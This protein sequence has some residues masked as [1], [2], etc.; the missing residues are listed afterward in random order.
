M[1]HDLT[2]SFLCLVAVAGSVHAEPTRDYVI[3]S[4]DTC[5]AIATRELGD[6]KRLEDIHRLNPNLGKAPHNLRPGQTLRLPVA[7][8]SAAALLARTKG[9]VDVNAP[10]SSDWA[11]GVQGQ[12]LYKSWRVATRSE[13]T[14]KIQFTDASSI[15]MRQDTVVVVF[16]SAGS[17]ST[18]ARTQL[19][20]G[21][22]RSR[23]AALDGKPRVSIETPAGTTELVEGSAVLDVD[24][25]NQTKLANHGGRAAKLSGK[26][27]APVT[28]KAGWGSRVD[29][30]KAPETPTP[31]PPAP[32]WTQSEGLMLGWKGQPIPIRGEWSAVADAHAYRIEIARAGVAD[33]I[34]AR[35]EVPG[36]I[37]R[38]EASNLPMGDYEI[39]VATVN[40]KG[41]EGPPSAPRRVHVAEIEAPR[42]VVGEGIGIPGDLTC[43]WSDGARTLVRD[44]DGRARLTCKVGAATATLELEVPPVEVKLSSRAPRV[45]PGEM[46]SLELDVRGVAPSALRAHGYGGIEVVSIDRTETTIRVHLRAGA[47]ARDAA[48]L[49]SE[50]DSR[51]AAVEVRIEVEAVASPM[52][53]PQRGR[54]RPLFTVA[55]LVGSTVDRVDGDSTWFGGD[56][57]VHLLRW[58]SPHASVAWFDR[59]HQTYLVGATLGVDV[60]PDEA[61]A[62]RLLLRLGASIDEGRAGGHAGLGLDIGL[63]RALTLRVQT[64]AVANRHDVHLGVGLGLGAR[65]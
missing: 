20:R 54:K 17:S 49:I 47:P 19:Q 13:A 65:Y 4:G 21:V 45:H 33:V 63:T 16:G 25:K 43:E 58:L 10:G 44:E 1:M 55:G 15:E 6:A 35:L 24:A 11:G 22:L 2:L 5:L 9:S 8:S 46:F 40:A 60:K 57:S 36:S 50:A 56:V 62:L 42:P 52:P 61:E 51:I 64:D 14:A 7:K 29:V 48:V 12:D 59:S 31:L 37:H 53:P 26:V 28:V 3:R 23:L 27:G 39:T 32:T 41:L 30:G 18:V 38:M 34:E